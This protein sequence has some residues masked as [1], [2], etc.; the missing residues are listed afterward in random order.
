VSV[1]FYPY[2]QAGN[3][4]VG[5]GLQNVQ[6]VADGEPLSGRSRAEDDFSAVDED[7]LA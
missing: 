3:K 5:A 6:K 1:N 7:F 4:G 2:N